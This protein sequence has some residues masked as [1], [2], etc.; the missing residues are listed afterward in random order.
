MQ[1]SLAVDDEAAARVEGLPKE[2]LSFAT[3]TGTTAKVARPAARASRSKARRSSTEASG[4][5]V[6]SDLN[7]MPGG[8]QT[9]DF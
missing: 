2:L 6:A 8:A 1:P 4:S 3:P 7:R 9:R 5:Q